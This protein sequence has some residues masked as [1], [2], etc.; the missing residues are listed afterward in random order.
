MQRLSIG[1]LLA[2]SL[3]VVPYGQAQQTAPPP[4]PI[5]FSGYAYGSYNVHVD[6]AAKAS[7]GGK[8]PN[9]FSIDRIYLTFRMPAGENGAIRIT[10][11]IYQQLIAPANIYNSGWLLKMKY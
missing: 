10:T 9:Q 3:F 4:S 7:L 5:D 6:S 1:A 2:T 8:A 11:D